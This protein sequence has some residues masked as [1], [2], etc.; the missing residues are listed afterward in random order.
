MAKQISDDAPIQIKDTLLKYH[1]SPI[2]WFYGQIKNYIM[3]TNKE[4]NQQ[5]NKIAS[6]I[7]FECGPVVGI[8][9]RRT[10]KIQEAKLFK[11]DDYMKW[12]E[13][14]FDVN[15]DKQQNIKQNY[16][17]NK[18]MLYIATDE[19]NVFKEAK[20][21]YGDRYEI[22][23]QK[24]FKNETLYKSK[25]ALIELL[26]LYHI[27]SKCQF[28]VC[29]LSSYTCR[30]VYE[31]MQVFQG[32]AS[33]NVH[34][35]DYLYGIDR[36][37]VAIIEYKPKHEHPIMPEEL[38]ADKGDVIVATSPVHK[39]GFIRAKNI[40][41]NKEGNF[42]MYFLKKYTKFDNFSAFDNV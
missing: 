25:E 35:L 28:L 26:A 20:I 18:R 14:W 16:C 32:D 39:D 24:V 31:L 30:T 1:S 3:K 8:H 21:K 29:T 40:Y 33:G 12:V 6:K 22:Y 4:I 36:N 13:F 42:P 2:I 5:I 38:W 27:L 41:S 34:S 11:L 15:E 19:I 17:T 10:D 7:P 23:H 9:V 37:Q